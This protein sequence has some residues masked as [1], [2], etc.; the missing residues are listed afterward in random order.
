MV[1]VL[2]FRTL[3][4]FCSKIKCWFSVLEFTKC[5]SESQSGKTLIRLLLQ[6]KY[7]LSLP[8]LARPFNSQEVFEILEHLHF[9]NIYRMS[10]LNNESLGETVHTNRCTGGFAAGIHKVW[11]QIKTLTIIQTYIPSGHKRMGV[12]WRSLHIQVPNAHVHAQMFS[13]S[14]MRISL[15]LD[16][17]FP[18]MWHFHKCRLRRAC[19]ASFLAQKLQMMFSQQLYNHRIVQKLAKDLIR[20]RIYGQAGLSL[21]WWQIPHCWKSHDQAQLFCSSLDLSTQYNQA[22]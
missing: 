16:M 6:K 3:F 19:A 17:R 2:K 7:D 18:T 14:Y 22:I 5:L 15:S 8:C 12:Y 13:C 1:N 21:C 20:Q 10:M 9:Q 4:S 11:M